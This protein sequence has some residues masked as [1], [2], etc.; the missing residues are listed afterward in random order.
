MRRLLFAIIMVLLLSGISISK[1]IDSTDSPHMKFHAYG[2]IM[3]DNETKKSN[4]YTADFDVTFTDDS[5]TFRHFEKSDITWQF[6]GHVFKVSK[7]AFYSYAFDAS[8]VRCKVWFKAEGNGYAL[9]GIEYDDKN[10]LYQLI[11][12][13]ERKT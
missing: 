9:L 3:I 11:I 13:K 10:F 2:V 5:M 1:T 8:G 12:I 6:I 7:T 4:S